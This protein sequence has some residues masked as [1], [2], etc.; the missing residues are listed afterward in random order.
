M[1]GG[2]KLSPISHGGYDLHIKMWIFFFKERF[3]LSYSFIYI[4]IDLKTDK[5]KGGES[6]RPQEESSSS[7]GEVV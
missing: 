3:I 5:Q 7:F 4:V 1:G 2:Q 6:S